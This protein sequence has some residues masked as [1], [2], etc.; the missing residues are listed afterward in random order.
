MEHPNALKNAT[1]A[2]ALPFKNSADFFK[3]EASPKD[4]TKN[5]TFHTEELEPLG[6]KDDHIARNNQV[7]QAVV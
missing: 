6:T 7:E 3:D 1:E 5:F 4:A 2:R